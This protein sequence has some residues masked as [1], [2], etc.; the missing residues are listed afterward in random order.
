MSN[1]DGFPNTTVFS[2]WTK[3]VRTVLLSETTQDQIAVAGGPSRR[4]QADYESGNKVLTVSHDTANKLGRAYAKLS[5]NE[6]HP[7]VV[8]AALDAITCQHWKEDA[9]LHEQAIAAAASEP[10]PGRFYLGVDAFTR[11]PL[12]SSGLA[13]PAVL[14]AIDAPEL[15]WFSEL[16]N[17]I[18]R[19]YR[20]LTLISHNADQL[21]TAEL[22]RHWEHTKPL[23]RTR[24]LGSGLD[25]DPQTAAAFD[26]IAGVHDLASAVRRTQILTEN[27][28]TLTQALPAPVVWAILKANLLSLHAKSDPKSPI[29]TWSLLQDQFKVATAPARKALSTRLQANIPDDQACYTASAP[30]LAPWQQEYTL[31]TWDVSFNPDTDD[32]WTDTPIPEPTAEERSQSLWIYDTRRFGKLPELAAAQHIP[33]IEYKPYESI[34]LRTVERPPL[35]DHWLPTGLPNRQLIFITAENAWRAVITP[36]APANEAA[37]M[38]LDKLGRTSS[39]GPSR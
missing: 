13:T 23:G 24:H 3:W 12:Y 9:S 29:S 2:A 15:V 18:T 14:R 16:A 33:T 39:L 11:E 37:R 5:N 35:I 27:H 26:P 28:G 10:P 22:Q 6:I 25:T 7:S 32:I 19:H 17:N 8:R 30:Y 4:T 38:K 20:A 31:S 1:T 34:V 36:A 21:A